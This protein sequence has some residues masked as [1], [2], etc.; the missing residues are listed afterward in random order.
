MNKITKYIP[1]ITGILLFIGYL[2]YYSYYEYFNINIS[3]YLTTG[4][5]ILSFLPLTIPI[6]GVIGYISMMAVSTIIRTTHNKEQDDKDDDTSKI[7]LIYETT[8]Y[9]KGMARLWKNKEY[10][11]IKG[12]IKILFYFAVMLV[13]FFLTVLFIIFPIFLFVYLTAEKWNEIPPILFYIISPIW[14]VGFITMLNKNDNHLYKGKGY[15]ETSS[16][17][18][19]FI[20]CLWITN[21][22]K[23]YNILNGNSK[24]TVSFLY[25]DNPIK[26]DSNKVYIGKTNN[27]IF[28]RNLK[29]NMNEIYF[30]NEV[31]KIEV[32]HLKDKDIAKN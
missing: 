12:I 23:A 7:F 25:K 27:Y 20:A 29:E 2:N 5:L 14:F 16:L 28:L 32:T 9:Y 13:S 15:V 10:K 31:N 30:L 19:L 18:M 24:V 21:R 17:I 26:T 8:K 6:L 22:H 1:I 11:N 4:E 3:T